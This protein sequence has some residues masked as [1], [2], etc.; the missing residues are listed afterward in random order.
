MS[1]FGEERKTNRS[2]LKLTQDIRRHR[3]SDHFNLLTNRGKVRHFQFL[4][5]LFIS[6]FLSYFFSIEFY[7]S[8]KNIKVFCSVLQCEYLQLRLIGTCHSY[9]LHRRI[10]V[11]RLLLLKKK[12]YRITS[13]IEF[14]RKS[15]IFE[16]K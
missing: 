6:S 15:L 13:N 10:S 3:V 12:S 8:E 16:Q 9:R 2:N 5:F 11:S 1:Q 7:S 4:L 14:D